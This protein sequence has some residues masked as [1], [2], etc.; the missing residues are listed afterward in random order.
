M[1]PLRFRQIHLDFHTSPLITPIA[2]EF[3]PE[4]FANTLVDAGVDS[5]TCF[6]PCHHGM[7]YHDT[8]F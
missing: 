5:I 6:S 8:Q 1:K 2:E 4:Y 7:I 3:D